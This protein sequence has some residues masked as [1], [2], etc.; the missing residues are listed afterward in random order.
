M[1]H[2]RVAG[3]SL[4]EVLVAVAVFA[5]MATIAYGGLSAIVRQRVALAHAQ[6]DFRTLLRTITLL[7]RDLRQAT[8]RSVRDNNGRDLPAFIGANDHL[9]F[10]RLGFANP[11]AEPRSNLERV[12]Y[13]LDGET[14]E[15]G[16]FNVLDRAQGSAPTINKLREGTTALRIRYL[17]SQQRWADRWPAI[18]D[19]NPLQDMP[20][21]VELRIETKDYGEIT[22]I[23]ELTSNWPPPLPKPPPTSGTSG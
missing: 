6:D 19:A 20:R 2:R 3:F 5:A 9:E 12:Q 17:D 22:R 18:D 15:R 10:T 23:I 16:N 11:Q 4:I 8:A 7:D 1:M 13:Q 14:F 21:A